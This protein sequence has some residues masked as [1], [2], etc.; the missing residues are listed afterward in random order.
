MHI[1][2]TI[3]YTRNNRTCI[4]LVERLDIKDNGRYY[5]RSCGRIIRD[6]WN[7]RVESVMKAEIKRHRK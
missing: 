6:E 3:G 7:R 5:N 1:F 2:H 4:R